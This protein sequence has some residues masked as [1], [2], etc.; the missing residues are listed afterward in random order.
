MTIYVLK[1]YE[2]ISVEVR[3]NYTLS[4]YYVNLKLCV[5]FFPQSNLVDDSVREFT[6]LS[7]KKNAVIS[8]FSPSSSCLS[9]RTSIVGSQPNWS[10]KCHGI[11][12]IVQFCHS[13]TPHIGLRTNTGN[14]AIDLCQKN[15]AEYAYTISLLRTHDVGS[16]INSITIFLPPLFHIY[17]METPSMACGHYI[18]SYHGYF[19]AQLLSLSSSLSVH[20]TVATLFPRYV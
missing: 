13:Y 11:G 19:F 9:W 6:R 10:L 1:E 15:I 8:R 17:F 16:F 20:E 4:V 12:C 14:R 5:R 2:Y 7:T 18:L 3:R